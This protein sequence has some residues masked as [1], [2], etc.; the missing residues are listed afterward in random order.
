MA[1]SG[2]L[3]QRRARRHA[4]GEH[5]LCRPTALCRRGLRLAGPDD[6]PTDLADAV[7][8]ELAGVD[9]TVMAMA[10]NLVR[11]ATRGNT[12]AQVS[13]TRALAELISAQRREDR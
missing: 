11:V 2:A 13:A 12:V 1:D 5:D 7:R 10:M 8:N 4:R 3:R 6:E 9:V